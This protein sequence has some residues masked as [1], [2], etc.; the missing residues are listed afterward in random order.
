MFERLFGHQP[1]PPANALPAV[2]NI[3][4]G[5]TVMVD[6]LAWRRFGD[7]L[8]FPFTG[9][10]LQIVAQGM[11]ELNDGGFIHRFYTDDDIML[12]AVTSDRGGQ[13]ISDVTLFAPWDSLYPGAPADRDVWRRRLS[14]P[15]FTAPELP[16][17]R[18]LWFG[19]DSPVQEPVS[20]WED[21]HDDRDG[22]VDR[23]I[24]QV[25]MLFARPLGDDGKELL[26]AMDMETE[27]GDAS[28]EIMLGVA[29][30]AG[31]FRA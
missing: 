18:R 3:T 17:Y 12:Q 25:C 9:D 15:V 11:V 21:V 19:D 7:G 8:K 26:L 13:E 31:E 22:I 30:E 1:A 2:R 14:A 4:I 16:D 24:F 28:F 29:L 10:T 5:R 23:R 6:P 20:F 27:A